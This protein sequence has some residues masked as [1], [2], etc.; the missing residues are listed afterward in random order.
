MI[1]PDVFPILPPEIKPLDPDQRWSS[2]QYNRGTLCLEWGPDNWEP[3]ITGADMLISTHRLLEHENPLG[4]PTRQS[5]PVPSRHSLTLGQELR[6]KSWRSLIT[7]AWMEHA[8]A[9]SINQHAIVNLTVQTLQV[10]DCIVYF[11]PSIKIDET[12]WIDPTLP[13]LF[14]MQDRRNTSGILLRASVSTEDL[15]K[16]NSIDEVIDIFRAADLDGWPGCD[17]FLL[18]SG[19]HHIF[20]LNDQDHLVHLVINKKDDSLSLYKAQILRDDRNSPRLPMESIHLEEKSVAVIGAGSLGSKVAVSLV[21]SGIRKILLIDPDVMLPGNIVRHALDWK[22][23]GFH[24]VKAL[25]E[26]LVSLASGIEVEVESVLI[27]GQE[28]NAEMARVIGKAVKYDLLVDATADSNVF[29]LLAAIATRAEIPMVWGEVYAGGIGGFVAR[30]RPVIGPNP[31]DVRN[32]YLDFCDKQDIPRT[33]LN[34][35]EYSTSGDHPLVASDADVSVIA[36]HVVQ[37][38][39]DSLLN[40]HESAFPQDLYLIGLKRGWVFQAPFENHAIQVEGQQ[41]TSVMSEGGGII[42]EDITTEWANFMR[43][44]FV[45]DDNAGSDAE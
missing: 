19:F 3:H 37:L 20:I 32:A 45:G 27:A 31:R 40:R 13:Q 18:Q 21:R 15:L 14:R 44:L 9:L 1:Y 33:L 16:I 25:R 10:L 11:S 2:H 35:I 24:K 12:E 7:D 42:S 6:G 4:D 29:N 39:L 8:R 26:E 23:V 30:S 28:S 41:N 38:V 5:I 17:G 22:S 43:D 34:S 36:H